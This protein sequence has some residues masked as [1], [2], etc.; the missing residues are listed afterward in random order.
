ML[1]ER[2]ERATGASR[3]LDAEIFIAVTPGVAEAGRI[4]RSGGC[5]GWW[6]KDGPYQSAQDSPRYTASLDAAL[7]LVPEGAQWSLE[8]DTAWVRVLKAGDVGEFQ[9]GFNQRDGKCTALAICIA[10]L[11]ARSNGN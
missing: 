2:L 5:V 6:P 10:S 7:T 4:D 1:I 3:E 8:A 11:K 9:G